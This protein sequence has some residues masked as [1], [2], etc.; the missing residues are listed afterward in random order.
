[1]DRT[2]ADAEQIRW[3]LDG[4]LFF[5]VREDQVGQAA[6]TAAVDHG[7]SIIFDLAVGGGFPDGVCQCTTPTDQTTSGGTMTVR[8]VS[9]YDRIPKN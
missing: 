6:W 4:H 2:D 7:Y 8:Y 5:R 9:V 1:V 3:Y